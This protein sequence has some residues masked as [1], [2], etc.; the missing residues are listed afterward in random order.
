MKELGE[1]LK[2]I[3]SKVGDFFD[4][5]DLSFFV[6][7]IAS[8]SAIY[9]GLLLEEVNVSRLFTGKI[10]L[11]VGILACYVAGLV[12]FAS[13]RWIRTELAPRI[14]QLLGSKSMQILFDEHLQTV[15]KAHGLDQQQLF[16]DYIEREESRGLW[17][18]YTRLWA[19]VRHS[20]LAEPS[21]QLLKRYWV[22]AATYDG[23]AVAMMI[24]GM[25]V[26]IISYRIN[27]SHEIAQYLLILGVV[28][29][30]LSF[31]CLREAGRY[32]NYQVEEIV[33]SIASERYMNEKVQIDD[34]DSMTHDENE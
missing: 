4:I 18:L 21:L 22:M 20:K 33:A 32:V 24:W 27:D 6:S 30:L 31:A 11:I 14:K 17:R 1:A 2:L 16:S 7:G 8:V 10:G 5:F 29:F 12:C 23:I 19:D 26:M 3:F 13:G 15:L 34:A 25:L 9:I 28:L